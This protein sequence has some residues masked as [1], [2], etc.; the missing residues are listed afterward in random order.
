MKTLI[1][2]DLL[3]EIRYEPETGLF[4]WTKWRLGRDLLAPA[5]TTNKEGYRVI[6]MGRKAY[7]A[8]RLAW[9]MQT[10]TWPAGEI[11]HINGEKSDNR[12]CNLRDVTKA[13]NLQNLRKPTARNK[14]GF[15]GVSKCRKGFQASIKLNNKSIHIGRFDTAESAH[16]AYIEAK[17]FLHRGWNP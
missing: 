16:A 9:L 10:G 2:Y 1:P 14:T 5:G 15:L 7:K 6:V 3:D 12:L 8:H 11:D 13:V 17:R 4:F